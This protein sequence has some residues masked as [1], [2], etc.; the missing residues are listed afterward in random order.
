MER[1]SFTKK[2]IFISNTIDLRCKEARYVA[3]ELRALSDLI[4]NAFLLELK[5]YSEN[6][7]TINDKIINYISCRDTMSRPAIYLESAR[8]VFLKYNKYFM[9]HHKLKPV[10]EQSELAIRYFFPKP[11]EFFWNNIN[12]KQFIKTVFEWGYFY[13]FLRAEVFWPY[14]NTHDSIWFQRLNQKRVH[15][16]GHFNYLF[17]LKV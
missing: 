2:Q 5:K 3:D 9:P 14:I 11:V 12:G 13:R 6:S 15:L 10:P 7:E 4:K 1:T 17:Y 16:P 8:D